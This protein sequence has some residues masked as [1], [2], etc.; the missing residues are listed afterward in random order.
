MAP[1]QP[2]ITGR[3]CIENQAVEIHAPAPSRERKK[4]L[5]PGKAK[6]LLPGQG[7]KE[8]NSTMSTKLAFNDEKPS[9]FLH[10]PDLGGHDGSDLTPLPSPLPASLLGDIGAV[11]PSPGVLTVIERKLPVPR[12][13]IGTT[14]SQDTSLDQTTLIENRDSFEEEL[15][16]GLSRDED[17]EGKYLP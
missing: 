15:F 4:T 3:T 14:T 16:R 13:R 12:S 10:I 5:Y 11:P 9:G 17:V 1:Q 2:T 6:L 8:N 7:G